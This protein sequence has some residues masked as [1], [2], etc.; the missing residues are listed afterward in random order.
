MIFDNEA[1]FEENVIAVLQQHGWKDGVLKYPTEHDLLENWKSILYRNNCGID[2]LG[3]YPLTDGEMAQIIEQIETLRTP[4]ALNSFVNGRT[5]SIKRDNGQDKAHFGKEVSLYIYDRQEIAGGKSTYQIAQQPVYPAKNAMLHSRRGDLVLLINGMP[6]IHIELKRSGVPVSQATNQIEKYAHEGVFAGLF[7]L[8]QVFV[9]MNPDDAVYFANPG[10][11]RFNPSYYFHWADWNNEPICGGKHPGE[12]EWKRFCA[13]LLSIPMAHQLIGFYT[14]A[15]SA[16]GCLKVL[17]SY[18]YYAASAISDAVRKCD[19]DARPAVPGRPGGCVWHTTGSGKTMTSF[20]S[21]Q[22]IADSKDAD[23][24][25]FLMDRIELGTQSLKEYQ[26][27]ADSEDDVQGTENT[28]V[29]R[30]KLSSDDPKDTLIVTSIQKMSNVKLGERGVTQAELDRL[31]AKRVVFIVD[32][33]HRSTFGDMLQDIRRSFPNAMFFGFTGT[34]I[35]DENQKKHATTAM[36]FGGCL[37]RYS[38]A[39]GIRDHNVLGF[40]PTMVTTYKDA[41][42]RL[43]VALHQA[44]ASSVEEALNDPDKADVYKHYMDKRQMPMASAVDAAGNQAPSIEGCLGTGEYGIGKPHAGM[45]VKDII[46]QFPV[47]SHGG[48]FHAMLATSSIPEAINYYHLFKQQAPQLRVTALFDPNIDNND[49]A[50]VKGD[51]LA[52]IMTDYNTTYGKHFGIVDWPAMKKD[53]SSRLSHKAPYGTIDA[54]RDARLDLLIVVDQMLTGFDSKWVNTLYLDKII[55]YESIIQAFSRTNRLFGPDKPFGTIRYYREPHTMRENIKAAVKLYSGD[56]PLDLFVQK[57]P[58]NVKAMDE[59]LAE[60]RD[61]FASAGA[62]DL[63]QLPQS[64]EAKR[65]FAKE[66]VELNKALEAAKIQGFTWDTPTFECVDEDGKTTTVQPQIDER[67]YLILAQRYKELFDDHDNEDGDDPGSEDTEAPYEL[68]GYLT[69]IDTGLIDTD[70]MNA[71]FD[72]WLKALAENS[73][74]LEAASQELHRSFAALSA[75]EQRLAE[76][77]LHD[78]ERGDV[79]LDPGMTL[80]DYITRYARREKDEQIDKLVDRTGVDRS[81][82]DELL[83]QHVTELTLNE[84]GRFDALVKSVDKKRAK[85][86]LEQMRHTVLTQP[87][88]NR[89]VRRILTRFVLGG[90]YD[91]D[92]DE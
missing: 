3:Q 38:I 12:D 78:V 42:V 14:V 17:R 1:D 58:D 57:L 16:D 86:A 47:L 59:R 69:E 77:F 45:V 55:R 36:I 29:L 61:V 28:G 92:A 26:S 43:A 37:H 66:F 33:C 6:L 85:A 35:L 70:Y 11:D 46:E 82:L 32:E 53:I 13:K 80:R 7:R 25:I 63:A 34:P 9:A 39:D 51:A 8:V 71:N 2:Q 5:V 81:L 75:D 89:E 22:L 49:G 54:N 91:I 73:P 90:G 79:H 40:D 23:K 15:D 18:Q 64:V 88:A 21:A 83:M 19:W 30:D 62:G 48:K 56:R 4:L 10:A 65:K 52:E 68:E 27:F 84:Y 20:K 24:V 72:K 76:L 31:A 74:E 60:I 67:T 50:T 41:D 44:K 87:K